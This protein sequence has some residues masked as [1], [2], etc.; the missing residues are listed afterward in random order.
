MESRTFTGYTFL[1]CLVLLPVLL[2]GAAWP[3]MAQPRSTASASV[4]ETGDSSLVQ[5]RL[6]TLSTQS[7]IL[8]QSQTVE[9][10]GFWFE[11]D[12]IRWQ[13]FI[14]ELDDV[15]SVEVFIYKFGNPGNMIVEI[16]T[17]DGT[18][19][20]QKTIVEAEAPSLGWARAEFSIPVSVSPGTKYRI[21]L[22]SDTDSPSTDN[23][24]VWRGNTA[25]TYCSTCDT[26][27][28]GGW[29]DYDYAFKTYGTPPIIYLPFVIK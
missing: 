4:R 1:V 22:Y 12:V 16:R 11:D 20:A 14:P 17:T 9:D 25:S 6:F 3:T 27:V 28:S 18:T 8:D 26:D 21:Y 19:L 29:P 15:T 10:Y 13:E 24:Y 2:L 7:E 23:R 5:P